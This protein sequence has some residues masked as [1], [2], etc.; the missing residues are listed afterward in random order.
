MVHAR[1]FLSE[2]VLYDGPITNDFTLT[3]NGMNSLRTCLVTGKKADPS[4]FFRFTLTPEGRVR[5]DDLKKNPGRGG[6]VI[7]N[8]EALQK[9]PRLSKKISHFLK[10]NVTIDEETV[11]EQVK[12]L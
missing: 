1:R 12:K 4:A 8:K 3:T 6:Y 9:L 2:N 7:K 5:F 10:K 11:Q